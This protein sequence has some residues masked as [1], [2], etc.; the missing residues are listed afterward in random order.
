MEPIRG[1]PGKQVVPTGRQPGDTDGDG[2]KIGHGILEW[3]GVRQGGPHLV[4][5]EPEFRDEQDRAE[6]AR[7]VET[8]RLDAIIAGGGHDESAQQCRCGVVRMALDLAGDT[9]HLRHRE[10][11]AGEGVAGEHPTDGRGR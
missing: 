6:I 10:G 8:D 5:R 7:R 3:H 9:Q 1:Q 11:L 2:T 4:G